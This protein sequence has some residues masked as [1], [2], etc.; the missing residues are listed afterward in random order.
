MMKVL[1]KELQN[2]LSKINS[3]DKQILIK[4]L[5]RII[6]KCIEEGNFKPL[7]EEID[8]WEATLELDQIP[9]FKKGIWESYQEIIHSKKRRPS[10]KKF[11]ESLG[12]NG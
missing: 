10:W 9:S 4:S 3:K 12:L 11:C 2:I 6:P 5:Q 7:H 1:E 8:S